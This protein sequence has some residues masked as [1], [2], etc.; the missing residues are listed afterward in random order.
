MI[1][2][3]VLF[4]AIGFFLNNSWAQ[5]IPVVALN[6][7]YA[8][9]RNAL[10][11]EGWQPV[12]QKQHDFDAMAT[13]HKNNGWTEVASCAGSGVAPCLFIWRNRQGKLLEVVT[14]GEN[15]RFNGFR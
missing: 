6:T 2:T 12:N 5:V 15:P 14:V 10:I 11:Q 7:P 13:I 8:Q 4:F 3:I 1:K 9:V